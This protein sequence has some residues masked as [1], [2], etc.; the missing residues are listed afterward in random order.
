MEKEPQNLEDVLEVKQ[1]RSFGEFRSCP[2]PIRPRVP[3][4]CRSVRSNI[5]D[6]SAKVIAELE[7]QHRR[8]ELR[9]KSELQR[10]RQELIRL[11]LH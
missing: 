10:A 9:W 7:E 11:G 5:S 1:V 3:F 8:R 6:R 2:S 4:D